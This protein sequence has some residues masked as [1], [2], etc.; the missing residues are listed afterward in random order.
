MSKRIEVLEDG[1]DLVVRTVI[2]ARAATDVSL[3]YRQTVLVSG[4]SKATIYR[5]MRRGEFPEQYLVAGRA[6]WSAREVLAWREQHRVRQSPNRS[7]HL[8]DAAP[9]VA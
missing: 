6:R 5:M 8:A 4:L 9:A 3:D 1:G 2:E 7:R